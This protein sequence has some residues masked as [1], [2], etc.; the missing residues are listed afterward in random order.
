M[1]VLLRYLQAAQCS[2]HV[3]LTL[4]RAAGAV[5][6]LIPA[7]LLLHLWG[8]R[9]EEGGSCRVIFVGAMVKQELGAF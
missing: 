1:E 7:E 5:G 2:Q 6:T 4:A 8:Q 9:T 3:C